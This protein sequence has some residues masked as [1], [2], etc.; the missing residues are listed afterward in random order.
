M[1]KFYTVDLKPVCNHKFI[2]AM[3]PADISQAG[4]EGVYLAERDKHFNDSTI[5]DGVCFTFCS[6]TYDNVVCEGQR[7]ETSAE[8]DTLHMLAFA[9]WGDTYDQIKVE[10]DDG[11]AEWIKVPFLDNSHKAGSDWQDLFRVQGNITAPFVAVSSGLDSR[12]ICIHHSTSALNGKHR[13]CA[14]TLPD[15][16]FLHVFAITLENS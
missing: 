14:I 8:A 12:L 5:A 16:M 3:P 13:V 15:N 2:Y 4:L 1:D 11:S 9:S 6:G 7:I 10:Y